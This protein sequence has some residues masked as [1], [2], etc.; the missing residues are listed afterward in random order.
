[1]FL[2]EY[3]AANK[4]DHPRAVYLRKDQI[5]PRLDYWLA[6]KFSAALDARN[7]F[8]RVEPRLSLADQEDVGGVLVA[9]R[10]QVVL[11]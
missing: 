1:V 4:I 10:P 2:R 5:L 11:H 9:R 3:A 6:G 7:V 8:G